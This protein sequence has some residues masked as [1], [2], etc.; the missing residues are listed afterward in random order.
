MYSMCGT[1]CVH[2]TFPSVM[3]EIR[4]FLSAKIATCLVTQASWINGSQRQACYHGRLLMSLCHGSRCPGARVTKSQFISF[5]VGDV[6]AILLYYML[7][8]LNH[9]HIRL[10]YWCLMQDCS[11]SSGIRADS[12]FAPSQWETVLLCNNVSH[13]LDTSL[14]SALGVT[15][16][17]H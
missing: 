17:L 5:L 1:G 6:Y 13:W 16:V 12:R 15:S 10:E 4:R 9:G 14:E 8:P 2:K 7:E 3:T 11:N